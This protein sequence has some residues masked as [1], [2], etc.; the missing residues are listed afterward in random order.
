MYLRAEVVSKLGLVDF[1][2]APDKYDYVFVGE[3][4]L[5]DDRLA[6]SLVVRMEELSEIVN[7]LFT[8]SIDLFTRCDGSGLEKVYTPGVKTIEDLGKTFSSGAMVPG[9]F[10][11]MT[12][13]ASMLAL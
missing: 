1:K 9:S 2:I 6:E 3:V 8:G 5:I 4:L 12:S 10:W 13:A 11:M 7:R